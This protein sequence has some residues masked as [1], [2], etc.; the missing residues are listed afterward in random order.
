[1]AYGSRSMQ[2]MISV[3]GVREQYVIFWLGVL[4]MFSVML[5]VIAY[6]RE[7]RD[8]PPIETPTRPEYFL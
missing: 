2:S 1:M 5:L 4:A 6:V 8:L 3:F 7:K